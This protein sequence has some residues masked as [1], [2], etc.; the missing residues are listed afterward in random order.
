MMK[1][2][3]A[4]A[5]S[6][7]TEVARR[8][9]DA[10]SW[11]FHWEGLLL[12][13]GNSGFAPPNLVSEVVSGKD[14]KFWAHVWEAMLFRHL[15]NLGVS[16]RGCVTKKGQRGPDFCFEHGGRTICIEAVMPE[17]ERIPNEWLAPPRRGEIKLRIMPHEP[18]LLR[19]TSVLK[20]KRAALETYVESKTIA[21]ADCTIIAVNC[22]RLSDFAMDDLGISQLPFAVEAVF[23]IGPLGI[24]ITSDGQP[25][26]EP[27]HIPRYTIQNHNRTDI[28]T[29]NF[30]DPRYANVSA[31]MSCYRKEMADGELP[32]TI[33]HNPLATAHLPT[34]ILGANKEYVAEVRSDHY[35]V[36]SV[37]VR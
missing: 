10:G 16:L 33:V 21:N 31:I 3:Q 15:T 25:A 35:I 2:T 9:P 24:P 1:L 20:K 8:F 34:G 4:Q 27:N 19:W 14:H 22:S 12:D 29:D 13:Y 17:P 11:R 37:H 7:R 32:L 26:G 18:M 23:P 36:R 30:L 6:I 5:A 28:S